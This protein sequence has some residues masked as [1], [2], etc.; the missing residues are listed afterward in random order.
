MRDLGIMQLLKQASRRRSSS[1]AGHG[2]SA[3][4]A[5]ANSVLGSSG[6]GSLET[7]IARLTGSSV[8]PQRLTT[9]LLGL[10][11]LCVSHQS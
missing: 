1:N 10:C 9:L 4:A 8:P 3:T 7:A 11:M 2:G 5:G 6:G